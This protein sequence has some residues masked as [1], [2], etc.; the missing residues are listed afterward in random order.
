MEFD[1]SET[2]EFTPEWNKNKQE[3]EDKQIKTTLTLLDMGELIELIAITAKANQDT[4]DGDPG[5]EGA[6]LMAKAAQD[7][8]PEHVTITNFHNKKNEE[9]DI[10]TIVR[11]PVFMNFMSELLAA[12]IEASTPN[13]DDVG[14][15]SGQPG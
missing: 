4:V 9:L 13:E 14:N 7:F 11:F 3:P 8:L 6:A 5:P 12:L 15:L 1:F 10:D 2:V